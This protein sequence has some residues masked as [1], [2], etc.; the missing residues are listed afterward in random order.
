MF[1]LVFLNAYCNINSS[2]LF[3]TYL[4]TN[5][6]FY[7]ENLVRG[8]KNSKSTVCWIKRHAYFYFR[9]L[10]CFVI[11]RR[12]FILVPNVCRYIKGAILYDGGR[13][14]AYSESARPLGCAWYNV[15]KRSPIGLRIIIFG[16]HSPMG[17]RI[18]YFESARPWSCA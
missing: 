13:A 10:T 8:S 2:N 4:R 1:Y 18:V 6:I 14:K 3:I 17:L 7:S 16:E 9:L 15:G 11:I 12:V 5:L